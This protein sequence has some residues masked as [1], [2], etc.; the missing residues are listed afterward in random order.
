MMQK[1]TL[2][3]FAV[4]CLL[5][6]SPLIAT[7]PSD[8]PDNDSNSAPQVEVAFVLDTTGSMSGLIAGAKQKI[9]TI[10][11]RLKT[12]KPTPNIRFG[13][14]GY[15]DRGDAYITQRYP[16][17]ENLDEVHRQLLRFEADGGGDTPESVNQALHEAVTAFEWSPSQE[18]MKMI[19]LV[20]D[21][22]PHMDYEDDVKYPKSVK[23]AVSKNI[24]I[25][26]IQ[27][28]SISGT[29]VV[30]REISRKAEGMYA[31]ILGD[32]GNVASSTP[33]DEEIAAL[34]R[35]LSAT[36]IP[37]GTKKEQRQAKESVSLLDLISTETIADRSEYVWNSGKGK[38]IA[39]SGDL[40][41][42]IIEENVHIDKLDESKLDDSLSAMNPE[43]RAPYIREQILARQEIKESLDKLHVQREKRLLEE[44]ERR[45]SEGD[46]EVFTLSAFQIIEEKAEQYGFTIEK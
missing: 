38:A 33:Y 10:A 32:G 14:I 12:A 25:N 40:I 43:D 22:P 26:T 46:D 31:A 29:D 27:C 34:N 23:L 17:N 16:L 39:S 9:W 11:N 45:E 36:V 41:E 8:A 5:S 42:E 4:L 24:I 44:R 15:R 13:L 28:G 6:A 20:G 1:L 7:E 30:W 2:V 3:L 18:V 21:A 35:E 37:Y 19:F